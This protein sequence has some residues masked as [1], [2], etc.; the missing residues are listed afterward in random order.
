[1]VIVATRRVVLAGALAS[2]AVRP[3]LAARA[4]WPAELVAAAKR[5]IGVTTHYDPAYVVLPY[6]GGDIAR[7]RGVCTDVVIRAYRDA[8]DVDLQ[9]LVHEDMA[10]NFAAYPKRW[11]LSGPN[12]NID[13]RRV[14]NLQTFFRRQGAELPYLTEASPRFEDGD[15]VT[16][17]LP[18]NLDHILIVAGTDGSNQP[19]VVHNIG[20]GVQLE[21]V[22]H[23]YPHSGHFRFQPPGV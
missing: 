21:P 1:M 20:H 6:P 9:R 23:V 5:Q 7:E 22:L 17:K 19:L 13:H 18:G 2:M 15:V 11:G 3:A 16:V 4:D 14:P 12:S 10:R 8:F